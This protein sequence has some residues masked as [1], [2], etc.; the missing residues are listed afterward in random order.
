V[1]PVHEA[2]H[3]PQ[4]VIHCAFGA[5]VELGIVLEPVKEWPFHTY[6]FLANQIGLAHDDPR[7]PRVRR[8]VQRQHI[9]AG[10]QLVPSSGTQVD[11]VTN[12]FEWVS[13]ANNP[14]TQDLIKTQWIFGSSCI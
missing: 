3:F 9:D 5:A 12:S 2:H 6:W 10:A 7:G 11:P 1:E 13:D 8:R 4:A 14:N